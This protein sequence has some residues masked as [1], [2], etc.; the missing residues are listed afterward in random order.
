MAQQTSSLMTIASSCLG[1]G[2]CL[3][4]PGI[5]D[6]PPPPGADNIV[7]RWGLCHWG[8]QYRDSCRLEIFLTR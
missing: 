5:V 3:R 4:G 6:T 2:K 1:D 8:A 7:H